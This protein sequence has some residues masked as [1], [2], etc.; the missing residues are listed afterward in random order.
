MNS[1]LCSEQY[2]CAVFRILHCRLHMA[3]NVLY[4]LMSSKAVYYGSIQTKSEETCR[5]CALSGVWQ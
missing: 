3:Y 5:E 2:E 1:Q 4:L